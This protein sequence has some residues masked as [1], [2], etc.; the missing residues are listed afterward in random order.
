MRN[1]SRVFNRP[2]GG[3]PSKPRCLSE[4]RADQ[5]DDPSLQDAKTND[6]ARVTSAPPAPLRS[7]RKWSLLPSKQSI[8]ATM[9]IRKSDRSTRAAPRR[10]TAIQKVIRIGE[11]S[12]S[13]PRRNDMTAM[14]A[15]RTR[16][17][18]KRQPRRDTVIAIPTTGIRRV[19]GRNTMTAIRAR[20][21]VRTTEDPSI[22]PIQ[23]IDEDHLPIHTPIRRP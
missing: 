9:M 11:A 8:I 14:A 3:S 22:N 20:A 23:S 13:T 15:T 1:L 5:E 6:L 4:S 18:A 21:Q 12:R 19:L 2:S 17:H 7:P 10:S 16:D